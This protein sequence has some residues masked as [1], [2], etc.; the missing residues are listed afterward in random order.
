MSAKTTLISG[1]DLFPLELNFHHLPLSLLSSQK[2]SF[3]PLTVRFF[4]IIF[5][6]TKLLQS[7][8]FQARCS[9]HDAPYGAPQEI[10]TKILR[11]IPDFV[12]NQFPDRLMSFSL[13]E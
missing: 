6:S 2:E 13:L 5:T 11:N 3:G 4:Q 8:Q 7:Q 9:K 10:L 12:H 1:I